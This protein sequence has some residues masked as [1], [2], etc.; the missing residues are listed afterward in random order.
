MSGMQCSISGLEEGF[1]KSSR[2][3][4]FISQ[5]E[6]AR[7]LLPRIFRDKLNHKLHVSSHNLEVKFHNGEYLAKL[8]KSRFSSTDFH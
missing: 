1:G 5:V 2:M 6:G 4:G 7:N 3:A 8:K